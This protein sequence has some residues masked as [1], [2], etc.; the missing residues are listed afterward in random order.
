MILEHKLRCATGGGAKVGGIVLYSQPGA[1]VSTQTT[2]SIRV[3]DGVTKI[4]ALAIGAGGGGGGETAAASA[5]AGGGGGGAL[6]YDNSVSVTPGETLS[7]LVPNQSTNGTTSGSTGGTG[8]SAQILRSATVLLSAVGGTGA[9][10]VSGSTPT[11]GGAGGAAASGVGSTKYSGGTGGAG[12][13]ATDQGGGGGGAAGY[14]GNGGTGGT[15]AGS[16]ASGSGGAGGGGAS[17]NNSTVGGSGGGT[18]WYGVGTS[19]AGGTNSATQTVLNGDLGSSLGGDESILISPTVGAATENNMGMPGGGGAGASSGGSVARSA[20]RGA[21]G[22]VRILWGSNLDFGNASTG[23]STNIIFYKGSSSSATSSITLPSVELGDTVTIID[24]AENTS[25]APTAVTP[26]GFTIR[27]NTTSGTRRLTT[28]TRQILSSAETGT[29]LTC[30]NGTASN[31]KIAIVISGNAGA[32]YSPRGTDTT[33]NGAVGSATAYSYFY[34]ESPIDSYAQGSSVGF[35]FFN[36]TVAINPDTDM[37]YAGAITV[38]GPNSYTY[39]KLLPYPQTTTSLNFPVATA[40]LGTNT[41]YF[42]TTKFF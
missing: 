33:G 6:S 9:V 23:V 18:L 42:W 15:A 12:N 13:A 21:G 7:V 32:S 4:A 11:A 31:A 39:V 28:Y 22:A 36:S 24:Y 26:S 27:L 19:G 20:M 35:L 41:Y 37:T 17:Y 38:P 25:G 8:L 34:S 29:V 2:Y 40:N 30:A 3:P 1:T 16:G 10:G 5:A 14:A